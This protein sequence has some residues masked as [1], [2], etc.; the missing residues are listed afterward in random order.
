MRFLRFAVIVSTCAVSVGC[1]TDAP[2]H[3]NPE[4]RIPGAMAP[5]ARMVITAAGV[6]AVQAALEP[7][8]WPEDSL[9]CTST[10]VAVPAGGEAQLAAWWRSPRPKAGGPSAP[11]T[12][13]LAR[14]SD[15]IT[16]G[17]PVSVAVAAVRACRSAPAALASDAAT[18]AAHIG[19]FGL[20]GGQAGI[21]VARLEPGAAAISGAMRVAADRVPRLVAIAARGDTIAVAYEASGSSGG[22]VRLAISGRRSQIPEDCGSVADGAA[23]VFAP[24]V[25]LAD[26]HVAV[27]WNEARSGDR[28]PAA[29]A[30][31]GDIRRPCEPSRRD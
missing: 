14:A 26:G 20:V 31:V 16:W 24:V 5:G 27:G 6:P 23:R 29:V 13:L 18:G 2:I 21:G 17:T 3:W 12:L 22:A 7:F 10:R 11:D 25:A 19:F 30:R 15:G 28:M 4:V 1:G 9:A 8:R